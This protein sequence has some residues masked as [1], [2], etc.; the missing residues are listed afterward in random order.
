MRKWLL[1]AIGLA[2]LT[3]AC[4]MAQ[5]QNSPPPG[6]SDSPHSH[7]GFFM[8]ADANNDGVVTRQEFEA[9]RSAGFARLDAN[10][11]GQL[12][13][14]EFRAGRRWGGHAGADRFHGR[15]DRMARLDANHDG[16]ISRAE[17]LTPVNARFDRLDGDHDGVISPQERQAMPGTHPRFV[18]RAGGRPNLDTNGDGAVARA[19][20]DAATAAMFERMDA[21]RDGRVTREEAEAG[22]PRRG[23]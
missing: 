3:G 9:S 21:N 11:D 7:G 19:E 10:H 13:R 15:G 4:G 16:A 23:D 2:A 1:T 18:G 14:D 8:R 12:S 6:A 20:W 5:A 22:R 17:F